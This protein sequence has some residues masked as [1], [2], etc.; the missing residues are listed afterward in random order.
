MRRRYERRFLLKLSILHRPDVVA[1]RKQFGYW[2]CDL[3]QFRKKF[4]KANV[5][6]LVERIS[7]FTVL[8]R[9][10]D[11]QSRPWMGWCVFYSPCPI[12]RADQLPL[13]AAP[14]LPNGPICKP[15]LVPRPG[16]AIH[17]RPGKSAWN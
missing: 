10:N 9:D 11:C 14:S 15:A 8:L 4:G 2:E 13:T 7:R 16:F 6:S 17:S 12:L 1:R 3:I 5:T